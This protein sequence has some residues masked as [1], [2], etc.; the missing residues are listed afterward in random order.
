LYNNDHRIFV[1]VM[2]FN[3]VEEKLSE[4]YKTEKLKILALTKQ[5]QY[6]KGPVR[7]LYRGFD[8]LVP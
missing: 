5:K 2:V 7:L 3:D 8:A 4:Q 6:T 1:A